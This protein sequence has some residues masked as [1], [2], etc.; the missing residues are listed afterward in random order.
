MIEFKENVGTEEIILSEIMSKESLHC[1]K[2]EIVFIIL[3]F[4]KLG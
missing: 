1:E 4:E 2:F 3:T